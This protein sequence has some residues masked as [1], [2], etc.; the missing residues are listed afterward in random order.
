[1]ENKICLVIGGTGGIGNAV[2]KTL[3]QNGY[4]VAIGYHQNK[5]KAPIIKKSCLVDIDVNNEESIHEAIKKIKKDLGDIPLYLVYSPGDKLSYESFTDL[6]WE[7]IQE[8]IDLF[9]RGGWRSLTALLPY[10]QSAKF[11][12]AVFINSAYTWATPPAR[13]ADYVIGKYAQMGLIKSAA[14]ELGQDGI[15]IN[16]VSPGM[17]QTEFISV[18]P[19][20]FKKMTASQN[21]MRRLANPDDVANAVLFLLR[22]ESA[23]LNGVDL[24]VAGGSVMR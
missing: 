16:S 3:A 2:C 22:D 13:L 15:T 21:P 11:G 12:R 18:V 9:A 14:V 20:L 7:K 10:M 23:Y 24:P 6:N 1:M 19:E 8:K 17:T 5:I 4:S